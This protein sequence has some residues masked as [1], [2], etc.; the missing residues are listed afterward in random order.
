MISLNLKSVAIATLIVINISSTI[1]KASSYTF[2]YNERTELAI[3][4]EAPDRNAALYKAAK[5]C[6]NVLT[7]GTYNKP[8][9]YPGDEPGLNIIDVCANPIKGLK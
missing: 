4:V 6:F 3:T 7:G 5:I 1:A 2:H 8:G 9:K